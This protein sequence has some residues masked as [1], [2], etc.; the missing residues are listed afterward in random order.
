MQI[1]VLGPQ[2]ESGTQITR[3]EQET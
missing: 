1:D 3:A 2:R